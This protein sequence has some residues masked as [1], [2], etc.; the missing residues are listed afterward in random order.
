MPVIG[1]NRELIRR[2]LSVLNAEPRPGLRSL[3]KE[4][5]VEPGNV[6]AATVGFTLAPR[7][8]AAG[9]MGQTELSVELLLTENEDDAE[10]LSA[11]LC[12]LNDERRNLEIE[13]FEEASAMLRE[14]WTDGPII[15]ARRGWYQG[16]TGIVAAKMAERHRTPVIIISID[17][18]GLG[19]GSCRSFGT[20]AIY[21][22]LRSCEDILDNYGGHEMAAGVTVAEENIGELRKRIIQYYSDNIG[23]MS[24]PGL[25]L[26]F[27]VEK[28]E[29]LTVQNVEALEKLEPFGNGNPSPCL[30]IKGAEISSAQS[31]G[32]G[33]HTRL[34]LEKSGKSFD[35]VFFSMSSDNLGVG[36]GTLVDVAFEPQ[37]NEF[38]GRCNVQLHLLDIR[39]AQ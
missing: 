6:T 19:R 38:R 14:S 3:L 25:K 31:I 12:R 2:G 5:C 4:V 17:E 13:I 11:D 27:E 37:I 30:C 26:D 36:V 28:P 34:R 39:T 1:E 18:D 8:N 10:R 32:A 16:V 33:K 20:F 23:A 9:R 29:L 24:S 15:L 35:C 21:D 22:V 7:L